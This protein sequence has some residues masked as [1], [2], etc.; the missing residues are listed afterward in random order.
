[1]NPPPPIFPFE[2]EVTASA[3]PTAAAASTALP[4][5]FIISIPTFEAC[6]LVETTMPFSPCIGLGSHPI[7]SCKVINNNRVFL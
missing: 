4:P 7:N 6:R 1:M 5:I 3:N 2:E